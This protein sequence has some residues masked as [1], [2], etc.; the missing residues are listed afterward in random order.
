MNKI[1]STEYPVTERAV[2]AQT[3]LWEDLGATAWVV[4]HGPAPIVPYENDAYT[5]ERISKSELESTTPR[6]VLR[7]I[8]ALEK[9]G[10]EYDCILIAH[11]KKTFKG[12]QIAEEVS[13]A[14]RRAVPVIATI[15]GALAIAVA[16]VLTVVALLYVL[17][18]LVIV[19]A[20]LY[21]M[22]LGDPVVIVVLKSSQEWLLIA[23][24]DE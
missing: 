18:P 16:V 19:G 3:I 8:E 4:G 20:I 7:R 11:E 1:I 21:A 5:L 22:T 13:D 15:L 17:V 6:E 2:Y 12:F 23:R 10:V 9:A 14:I 24:W